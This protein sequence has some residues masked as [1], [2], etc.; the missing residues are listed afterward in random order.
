MER[1]RRRDEP[2]SRVNAPIPAVFLKD[3]GVSDEQIPP[4]DSYEERFR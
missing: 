4:R 3:E 2:P 1:G